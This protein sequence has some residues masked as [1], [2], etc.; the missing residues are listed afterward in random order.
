VNTNPART[1]FLFAGL[2]Y[3]GK[4]AVI[5]QLLQRLPGQV[6][7]IDAIFKD[8]VGEDEI[9]L[10][11]WLEEGARLVD[12]IVEALND[13]KSPRAYVEIG[14]LRSVHRD[15]LMR[16]IRSRNFRL[17]PILLEC[18]SR[19]AVRERQERRA[20]NLALQPDKLKIAIGIEELDGPISDAFERPGDAD[21][22][23]ALDTSRPIEETLAA[24]CRRIGF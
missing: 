10:K 4:T 7:Y 14:I 1:V 5:E 9:C 21:A 8:I 20:L 23:L 6:L 12:R 15:R 18:S 3:S 19:A 24:I 16:W 22:F 11:R 17:I 13:S 2:P